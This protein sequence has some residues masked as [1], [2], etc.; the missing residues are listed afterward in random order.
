MVLLQSG[1]V[2]RLLTA[3]LAVGPPRCGPPLLS[4]RAV[5]GAPL[6]V[7]GDLPLQPSTSA[8]LREQGVTK[9][10]PIQQAAMMRLYRGESAVLHSAT[11]SG[12][13]LAYLLPLLQR[14]HVSKPGQLLVVVPSRELAL[15]TAAAVEWTWPHHGTQR[16]FLL[17]A[18]ASTAPELAEAMRKAACPVI[19][20]TPRPLL[21]LVRHMAGTDRI[22]SRRAIRVGGQELVSFASQLRAVVLDEAD[23]LVLSRQIAVAGPPKAIRGG[24]AAWRDPVKAGRGGSKPAGSDGAGSDGPPV[25]E[26]ERPETFTLP[27]PRSVQALINARPAAAVRGAGRG[28]AS[29]STGRGGRGKAKPAPQLQ[30]VACSATVSYRLTSEVARLLS[31]DDMSRLPV[32]TESN[33][34]A[35]TKRRTGERGRGAVGVPRAIVHSW[36]PVASRADKAAGAAAVLRALA[37]AAALYFVRDDEPVAAALVVLRAEGLDARALHEELGMDGLASHSATGYFELQ[38]TLKQLLGGTQA[39]GMAASAPADRAAASLGEAP[40]GVLGGGSLAATADLAAI[41]DPLSARTHVEADAAPA[42]VAAPPCRAPLVLVSSFGSARGLDLGGE[43]ECVVLSALPDS[44]DTYL[45][46]AGRTGRCGRQGRVVT[47]LAPEERGQLGKITRQLGVSIR[48]DA[49][50]ALSV[51]QATGQDAGELAG[52]SEA[53]AVEG[54]EPAYDDAEWSDIAW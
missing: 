31:L 24:R 15:Q 51:A 39:V 5:L 48:G 27:V 13:T 12:K 17:T 33:A 26:F 49:D 37:P 23:A 32:I 43:V 10:T 34:P 53:E 4:E 1:H 19:I 7:F 22:Y 46:L 52:W 42:A 20:A 21:S 45:H 50:L 18:T 40:V 44:A 3:C 41:A 14:L 28:R 47:L 8:V 29:L 25:T 9:P 6:P 36:V 30:L 54:P 2:A 11:G 35:P 38:R 16:A